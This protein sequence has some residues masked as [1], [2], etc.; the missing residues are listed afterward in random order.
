MRK[1]TA[2]LRLAVAAGM[3]LALAVPLLAPAQSAA[4]AES[5]SVNLAA[6]TGP[7]TGVGEGFL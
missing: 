7:A 4:A 6:V 1:R 5:L 2:P 3:L